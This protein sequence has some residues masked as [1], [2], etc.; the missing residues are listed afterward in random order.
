M[1]MTVS[2]RIKYLLEEASPEEFD[3][4]FLAQETRA[5]LAG[6]PSD[7]QQHAF[8]HIYGILPRS[9]SF[10]TPRLWVPANWLQ[11]AAVIGNAQADGKIDKPRLMI[12]KDPDNCVRVACDEGTLKIWN[13]CDQQDWKPA[14]D[15]T[16]ASRK[17][18]LAHVVPLVAPV[19]ASPEAAQRRD[20]A[21]SWIG[22]QMLAKRELVL[23][24][25]LF[26]PG[27][28]ARRREGREIE[29]SATLRQ[30]GANALRGQRA[31]SNLPSELYRLLQ[32][33]DMAEDEALAELAPVSQIL[34][35]ARKI[36]EESEPGPNLTKAVRV[37]KA[38]Q[39]V[40]GLLDL[41]PPGPDPDAELSGLL[42]QALA[43]A[44]AQ[45]QR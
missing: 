28:L 3:T 11:F 14:V 9:A 15:H 6:I 18:I 17:G 7:F 5:R 43:I 31:Q 20:E 4:E 26:Y 30:R 25:K 13:R 16:G 38:A 21:L 35:W 2:Q 40:W 12:F 29:Q 37:L 1:I 32:N 39:I 8:R 33:L 42:E 23:E 27:L 24:T 45:T 22:T 10:S 34:V 36:V 44:K 19:P 41:Q